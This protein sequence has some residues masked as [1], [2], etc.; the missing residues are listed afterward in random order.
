MLRT[1]CATYIHYHSTARAT[2]CPVAPL[3][4]ASTTLPATR[5]FLKKTGQSWSRRF[6]ISWTWPRLCKNG[7]TK[8]QILLGSCGQSR[9][10]PRNRESIQTLLYSLVSYKLQTTPQA[11]S[12]AAM[13]ATVTIA[14][15]ACC[16]SAPKNKKKITVAIDPA[17]S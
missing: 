4:H 7:T 17:A 2:I 6:A 3:D 5:M 12:S 11:S 14:W 9:V 13:P 10:W 1:V 8:L 16:S 15:N